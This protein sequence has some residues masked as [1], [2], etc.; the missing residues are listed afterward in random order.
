MTNPSDDKPNLLCAFGSNLMIV[1]FNYISHLAVGL[2][3]Q[4]CSFYSCCMHDRLDCL[5]RHATCSFWRKNKFITQ[6]D[7]FNEQESTQLLKVALCIICRCIMFW[8]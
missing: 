2:L 8:C 7:E 3:S 1:T 4:V 5:T 6:K